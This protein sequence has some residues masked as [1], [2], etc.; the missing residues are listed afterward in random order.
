VIQ[1]KLIKCQKTHYLQFK[2]K[3]CVENNITIICRNRHIFNTLSTMFLGLIINE[4]LSWKCYINQLITKLGSAC[5]AVR[6]IKDLMSQ[7]TL[8]DDLFFLR[9]LSYDM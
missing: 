9:I 7:K 8:K 6:I 3:N 1:N 4:T 5:Y 2:S